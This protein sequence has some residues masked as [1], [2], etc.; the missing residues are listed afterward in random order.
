[1]NAGTI[2]GFGKDLGQRFTLVDLLPSALLGLLVLALVWGGAPANSPD[3]HRFITRVED[4]NGVE[5]ALLA[6]A[7]L[8]FALLTQP[9]QLGLVR[10]ME[11]YWGTS[12]AAGALASW[13]R[14][15]HEGQRR[16]LEAAQMTTALDR[17]RTTTTIGPAERSYAAWALTRRYPPAPLVMPTRLGNALRA[18]EDRAGRRY[19]LDTIAAWPRLY[20][21]LSERVAALIKDQRSQVDVGARFTAV[22]LGATA[23]SA[24]LLIGHGWWLLLPTATLA[25][26]WLSYRGACSA[27]LAYG[28]GLE[29]AFDLHR[30]DLRA[31]LHLALPRT[32]EEERAMNQELSK[33]LLQP[34]AR[35]RLAY[36]H[37]SDDRTAPVADKA[38]SSTRTHAASNSVSSNDAPTPTT[39]DA[40]SKASP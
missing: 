35:G 33:F 29:A 4:L 34:F 21:L 36:E 2:L 12:R 1:M 5:G 22:F 38:G 23:I 14:K 9:L 10:L 15:R 18:A 26:A 3:L 6:V 19:G 25:L 30:F 27:A 40:S 24:G 8:G 32:L 16:K 7:L 28:D 31:G 13:S 20:P 11:G 17:D 39:P 37:P